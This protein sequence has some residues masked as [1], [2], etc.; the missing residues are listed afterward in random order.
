ML[1]TISN[2]LTTQQTVLKQ[3]S[4]P[5]ISA[6]AKFNTGNPQADMV[7]FTGGKE[8]RARREEEAKQ[9]QITEKYDIPLKDITYHHINAVKA[10]LNPNTAETYQITA[11]KLG[12]DPMNVTAREVAK[13]PQ[14]RA[15]EIDA[16][17]LGIKAEGLTL[18]ELSATVHDTKCDIHLNVIKEVL[19]SIPEGY[20]LKHCGNFDNLFKTNTTLEESLQLM[21]DQVS[22]VKDDAIKALDKISGGNYEPLTPE[23]KEEILNQIE[24]QSIKTDLMR[25]LFNQRVLGFTEIKPDPNKVDQKNKMVWNLK[26]R[27]EDM[28]RASFEEKLNSL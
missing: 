17:L 5:T 18:E 22:F 6:T 8:K 16:K 13:E 11:F 24:D 19:G 21:A 25:E 14:K 10:G 20:Q 15:L 27:V 9:L 26:C 12:L 28:K 23:R 4:Q 2:K 3:V 7:C 1:S